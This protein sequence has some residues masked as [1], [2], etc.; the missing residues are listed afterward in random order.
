VWCEMAYMGD[1]FMD[2]RYM[3][4]RFREERFELPSMHEVCFSTASHLMFVWFWDLFSVFFGFIYLLVVVD[5]V[6]VVRDRVLGGG[7]LM[8]AVKMC[9]SGSG[10]SHF[11]VCV[12]GV[13]WAL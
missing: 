4:D 6:V 12:A 8:V 13:L 2:D 11:L 7:V 9:T 1:R 5:V 3:G 10:V